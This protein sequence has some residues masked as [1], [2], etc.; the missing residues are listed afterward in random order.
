[1]QTGVVLHFK[2]NFGHIKI[3][4]STLPDLFVHH[5]DV[6]GFARLQAGDRVSFDIVM[7]HN[8]KVAIKVLRTCS[9]PRPAYAPPVPRASRADI[10]AEYARAASEINPTIPEQFIGSAATEFERHSKNSAIEFRS[11]K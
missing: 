11:I 1:M 5:S 2:N 7:R 10:F 4:D 6:Q 9:A 3:D 8:R